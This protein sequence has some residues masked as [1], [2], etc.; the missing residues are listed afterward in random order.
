MNSAETT[1]YTILVIDDDREL[2]LL[3]SRVLSKFGYRVLTALSAAHTWQELD[4][5]AADDPVHLILLDLMLPGVPGLELYH[6]LRQRPQT[7]AVPIVVLS[8]I[9]DIDKRV[10]LLN[11]GVDDYLV[12]PCPLDELTARVAMHI[13]LGQLRQ[14]KQTAEARAENQS[15]YLRAINE[16]GYQATQYL[17]LEIMMQKVAH[18]IMRQF[19]CAGCT[20]YLQNPEEEKQTLLNP[21]AT[22]TAPGTQDPVPPHVSIC[23]QM[24]QTQT[25]ANHAFI[26]IT[27]SDALLGVMHV[28]GPLDLPFDRDKLQ[29]LQALAVQLA[30]AVT[31]A[32]L[33]QD[34]RHHNHT[35]QT[36]ASENRRL[37]LVE[38]QQ[39][40]QAEKLHHMAQ[41]LSSSLALRPV[42][43]NAMS[44]LRSML[45]V[46]DGSIILI[47]DET[48]ELRFAGTIQEASPQLR[49][50][51]LAPDEGIVGHVISS[52]EGIIVN[53]VH[54][55]PHF[56]PYIDRITG[57]QTRS[58]LCVPLVAHDRTVGALELINKNHGDFT[59]LDLALVSSAAGSIAIAVDNARLYE[60]Q[61]RL[62]E[63]RELSQ[64]QLLQ[65]EKLAAAG[66]LAASMA[67]E[68][69]N[70][71]QAVHSCLQLLIQFKLGADKQAEYLNMAGEEVERLINITNRILDFARPSTGHY[72]LVNL[73]RIINQV[74][75][76]THKH[77]VHQHIKVQQTLAADASQVW[78][79]PDQI[80]QAFLN[81]ILNAIDAMPKGGELHLHT[82]LDGNWIKTN[83]VDTGFGIDGTVLEHI[84]EPFFTT[85]ENQP[86]LGLTISHGIVERHGGRMEV[87]SVVDKGTVVTVYLPRPLAE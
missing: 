30:T 29:A 48:Q 11:H 12:K 10:E 80:A 31:N 14:A 37:L 59:G 51:R 84:F 72:D 21:V 69:N 55:N 47:D 74:M 27:R 73:Q 8:A 28:E 26:P 60:E 52:G 36:V 40:Q 45:D 53:K 83:F 85:K 33:F 70:P 34:V 7:T 41:V 25:N 3:M 68:I 81:I 24:R 42:L 16:V 17:D 77:L 15:L 56:L 71:L 87:S 79:I 44:H 57:K 58:V 20:I 75:Q 61:E 19:A 86:G 1:T 4:A 82:E 35:L 13:K 64:K 49:E 18:Q 63:E 39:R 62:N 2:L 6:A 76:L 38:Q 46:E 50:A 9:N 66:R 32:Y 43:D 67:H 22:T 78:V 54:E 5:L 65:T 23:A